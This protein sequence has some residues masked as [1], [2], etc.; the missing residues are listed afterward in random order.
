MDRA[1]TKKMKDRLDRTIGLNI[2]R[3]R[4]MH[5]MSR[6]ELAEALDLTVSHMG[7]I[8]RGERGATAVTLHK[9]SQVFNLQIDS[10]F[11]EP[12]KESFSVREDNDDDLAATRRKITS[13][14]TRLNDFETR[15]ILHMI[16]GFIGEHSNHSILSDDN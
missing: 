16:T 11:A 3:E 6:E 9:L 12:D 10:L 5:K 14:L 2:R 13:L 7:L 15:M 1:N 8:E 4:E